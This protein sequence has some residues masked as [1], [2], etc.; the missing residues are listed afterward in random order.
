V[1]AG[2]GELWAAYTLGEHFQRTLLLAE[3]V[4][5]TVD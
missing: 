2:L 5:Q 1:E 3:A 4:D